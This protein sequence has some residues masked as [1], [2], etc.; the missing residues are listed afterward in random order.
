MAYLVLALL[1]HVIPL[2]EKETRNCDERILDTCYG[3]E[4]C[5]WTTQDE[6]YN[7]PFSNALPLILLTVQIWASRDYLRGNDLRN[8]DLHRGRWNQK[9]WEFSKGFNFQIFPD[10]VEIIAP[11]SIL[12]SLHLRSQMFALRLRLRKRFDKHSR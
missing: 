9:S 4:N 3:R 11:I 2:T 5:S 8:E 12:C 1:H 6:L 10:C 7:L